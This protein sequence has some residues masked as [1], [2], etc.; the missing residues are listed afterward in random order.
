[1]SLIDTSQPA[2][3]Q[4]D[5]QAKIID[6][7]MRRASRQKDMDLSAFS[8]FQSA[9]ELQEKIDAQS[10]DLAR[11]TTELESARYDR[12]RTRKSLVEA[13]S[14]M[15][16]GLALFA[17]GK[18]EV[19]NE[20]FRRLLPDVTGMISPG[21][22]IDRYFA[23]MSESRYLASDG[24][25]LGQALM[26]GL[27][28]DEGD[29]GNPSNSLVLELT[30]DRWYQLRIQRTSSLNIVVLFTEITSLVRRTRIEREHLIDRQADYLQAVFHNSSSGMCKLS[31][32][33]EIEMQNRQFREMLGVPLTIAQ[34]GASL[35]GLLD[36]VGARAL[37]GDEAMFSAAHWRR[38]LRAR[39][40]FERRVRPGRER[41][42]NVQA[43]T[44]PDGGFLIELTDVTL[45]ARTTETLETR[46]FERTAALTEANARLTEQYETKARVE[47]E[48]RL[49]KER[50]EEAVSSKTRF[51]AAA[52]HDLL[53]PINAAKLLISTL[54]EAAYGTGL[55]TTV[56][57]LD[58]AFAS[59]EYLLRSLLDISRLESSD[60]TAVSPSNV[61]LSSILE[62]VH[63]EQAL[64]AAEKNVALTVVSS[65]TVVRSDPLYLLRSVQN[66]LVNAIQYTPP[67]GRVLVGCRRRGD[68]IVLEVWDTGVGIALKDQEII[69]REFTR[70][71]DARPNT[72]V[73]LGLSIVERTCRNFGHRVW[74]RSKP[75]RGSVFHLEMD[76]IGTDQ[77]GKE[78]M[79]LLADQ[80]DTALDQIVLV[81]EN[82]EDVLFATIARLERWGASVLAARS[83]AEALKM[84]G[85][86]GM[87]PDI[88]LADYQL[89]GEERGTDAILQIRQM[90]GQHVPA[91]LITA[92]RGEHLRK[93]AA[94]Q[95]FAVMTKPVKLNRLRSLIAWKI[96]TEGQADTDESR[97]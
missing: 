61:S 2:A 92:N 87:P 40:R 69:F 17:D 62:A 14:S 84:V 32:T 81:V 48:L 79:R 73:G 22:Q 29:R 38:Q 97:P 7:L 20:L 27:A 46:V 21:M 60:H 5:R 89:D 90:F 4:L 65:T 19:F 3:V 6:A 31:P 53:Q 50:A 75:G 28:G 37:P 8:A 13:L 39:G 16:E 68:K 94:Q 33:C 52:S 23:L 55:S 67:G 24:K 78:P 80:D 88:V 36:Y 12:E 66:L 43:S 18:L 30:H 70:T 47:E 59:A 72:G 96:R 76:A 91:I 63:A 95:H 9:I 74:V 71:G 25:M 51:L 15:E 57:R 64:V 10:R 35:D 85:D 11:A 26:L 34:E 83:T 49:A 41:V 54:K 42:L 93:A 86:I 58:G 82:D 77:P 45:E 1:M 44:L 56:E